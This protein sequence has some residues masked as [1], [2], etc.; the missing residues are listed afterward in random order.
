MF[1]FIYI[2]I[3]IFLK[4]IQLYKQTPVHCAVFVNTWCFS[5]CLVLFF[6]ILGNCHEPYCIKEE[7]EV[8]WCQCQSSSTECVHHVSLTPS[9][10]FN[11]FMNA[12]LGS[13]KFIY[14]F[15]T[16]KNNV[17]YFSFELYSRGRGVTASQ[18]TQNHQ[19]AMQCVEQKL[20]TQATSFIDVKNWLP[21]CPN[22]PL[23]QWCWAPHLISLKHFLHGDDGSSRTAVKLIA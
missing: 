23:L 5:G 21:N 9:E 16:E 4:A 10:G 20:W 2:Y 15:E 1:I 18:P 8:Q 12:V 7:M 14:I 22:G 11:P 17:H 19:Y 6:S 3:Y 13:F